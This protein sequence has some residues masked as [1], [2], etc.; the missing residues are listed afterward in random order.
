MKEEDKREEKLSCLLYIGHLK[1][2]ETKKYFV[3]KIVKSKWSIRGI[4]NKLKCWEKF[5]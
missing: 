1:G 5:A 2:G 4:L 3:G